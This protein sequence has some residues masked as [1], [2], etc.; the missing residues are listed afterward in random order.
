[1]NRKNK[2]R[3]LFAG[4]VALAMFSASCS[5]P[6][7]V[8]RMDANETVDL[9]GRWNDSDSRMVA[10]ETIQDALSSYWANEFRETNK[11]KPVVITYGVKN[12][13]SE[14]INTQ[15][16]MKDLER[17]FLNSGKVRV[18]AS[19]EERENIRGER[20]DQ[21]MGLTK[22][23]AAMG[24]ERGADFVL[25]GSLNSVEDRVSGQAV[26]FYQ[27]DLTL[28]N[29]ATSEKVWIGGKKIKKMV[30]QSSYRY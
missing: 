23:P 15:T 18:V 26:V 11:R 3:I 1:M 28:I 24:K 21:Q 30:S 6:R 5:D 7:R 8:Q 16:F 9:S 17:A 19:K 22:N 20:A 14:H 4:L 13:T 10:Q 25:T 29:V 12:R 27:A 2:M